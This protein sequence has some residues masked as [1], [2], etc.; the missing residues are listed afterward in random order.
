ME[1]A[2]KEDARHDEQDGRA[3][4]SSVLSTE[5]DGKRGVVDVVDVAQDEH[6]AKFQRP[7]FRLRLRRSSKTFL[8]RHP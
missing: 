4:Q 1:A 8:W 6:R 3:V 2:D 7:S 5:G